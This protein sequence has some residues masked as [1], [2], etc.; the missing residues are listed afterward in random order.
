[1]AM[2]KVYK[3]NPQTISDLMKC[4]EN[5]FNELSEDVIRRTISNIRKRAKICKKNKGAHFESELK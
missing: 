3:E 2:S 5:F 1:M 4:V